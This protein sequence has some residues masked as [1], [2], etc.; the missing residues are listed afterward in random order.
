MTLYFVF[1]VAAS[2][3]VYDPVDVVPYYCRH[4]AAVA[5]GILFHS[6]LR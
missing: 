2:C 3:V 5:I 1:E 6:L 4:A